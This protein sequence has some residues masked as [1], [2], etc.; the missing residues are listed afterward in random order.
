MFVVLSRAGAGALGKLGAKGA[1]D[2]AL[3]TIL[4]RDD[5]GGRLV[6]ATFST[7]GAG[8]GATLVMLGATL[9]ATGG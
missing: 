9:G 1:G 7:A 3:D 5:T 8:G 2:G 6:F 4:G